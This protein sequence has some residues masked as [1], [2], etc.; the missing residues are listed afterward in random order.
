MTK[1]ARRLF[2]AGATEIS[3]TLVVVGADYE[4]ER[5]LFRLDG[6]SLNFLD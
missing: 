3:I 5:E 2:D 4:E 6:V 1:A